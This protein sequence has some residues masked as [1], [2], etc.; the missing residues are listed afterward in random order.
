MAGGTLIYRHTFTAKSPPEKNHLAKWMAPDEAEALV[1]F[2]NDI[3]ADAWITPGS[4]TGSLMPVTYEA[5][6][7]DKFEA[8]RRN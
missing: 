2:A 8:S 4:Y 7:L 3:K 5:G 6:L 1:R